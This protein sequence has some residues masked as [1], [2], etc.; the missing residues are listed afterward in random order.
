MTT[1]EA[2]RALRERWWIVL[3]ATVIA[4]VYT[5]QHNAAEQG[6]LREERVILATLDRPNP[7]TLIWPL[8]RILVPAAAVL[9]AISA[10]L[11]VLSMVYLD[12][13]VRS[14]A[15]VGRYLELPLL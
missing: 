6:K 14:P 7:A 9:G 8:T 2:I 4:A 13:T 10:G 5:R 11:V 12:D 15:D 1:L 3:A